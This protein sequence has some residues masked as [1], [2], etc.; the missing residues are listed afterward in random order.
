MN[1]TPDWVKKVSSEWEKRTKV[2][3]RLKAVNQKLKNGEPLTDKG[4]KAIRAYQVTQVRSCRV[5]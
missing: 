2:N 3:D 1:K 4:I 5:S